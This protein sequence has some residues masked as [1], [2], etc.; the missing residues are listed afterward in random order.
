MSRNHQKFTQT[1]DS[2]CEYQQDRKRRKSPDI[3]HCK[4]RSLQA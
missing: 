2:R 4:H 3:I 1:A